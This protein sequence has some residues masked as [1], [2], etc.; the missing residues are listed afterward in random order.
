MQTHLTKCR[1]QHPNVE[2][3]ECIYN[4]KHRIPKPEESFHLDTCI[5]RKNLDKFV[6]VRED[7]NC[8]KYK[9]PQL[10]EIQSTECWDDVSPIL[11]VIK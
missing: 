11:I 5:D 6:Y 7:V 2:M 3:I 9:V 4:A 8:D 1:R 10:E